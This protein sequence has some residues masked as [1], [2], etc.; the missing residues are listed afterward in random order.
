V[1][2]HLVHLFTHGVPRF[3]RDW[4]TGVRFRIIRE[5]INSVPFAHCL[6]LLDVGQFRRHARGNECRIQC[7]RCARFV[8]RDAEV[9]QRAG[10]LRC[11]FAF[12]IAIRIR[13]PI[14]EV[15]DEFKDV[16]ERPENVSNDARVIV[17]D[18][19]FVS[20]VNT[21]QRR[22][23]RVDNVTTPLKVVRPDGGVSGIRRHWMHEDWC[24]NDVGGI[25]L[26]EVEHDDI[27]RRANHGAGGIE[28]HDARVEGH[29]LRDD[30]IRL[31]DICL[32][33][34]TGGFRNHGTGKPNIQRAKMRESG[35]WRD[36]GWRQHDSCRL[37]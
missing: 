28:R 13:Y 35:R 36:L 10:N 21:R 32:H 34:R 37:E 31:R 2:D 30:G 33:V 8:T 23:E 22:V 16:G 12:Q 5:R 1:I 17:A 27:A 26:E 20:L 9:L 24:R 3:L 29:R 4:N 19:C 18:V 11:N 25:W 7:N 6:Q 15:G 14:H